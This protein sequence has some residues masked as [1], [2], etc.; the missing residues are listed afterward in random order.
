MRRVGQ[1]IGDHQLIA[2][3]QRVLVALGGCAASFCLLH[4][5]DLHRRRFVD[6]FELVPVCLDFGFDS[7]GIVRLHERLARQCFQVEVISSRACG[8]ALRGLAADE[9]PCPRCAQARRRSLREIARERGCDRIALAHHMDDGLLI[10]LQNMFFS[11]RLASLAIDLPTSDGTLHWIRPL[12]YVEAAHIAG[13]CDERKYEAVQLAC[14]GRNR[15][16][17]GPRAE[18][19]ALIACVEADFPRVRRSML[20]SLRHLRPSHL[21]DSRLLDL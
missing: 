14:P 5:L 2:G 17:H 4:M 6:D 7:P 12:L 13:F 20:A 10:L 21:L 8:Q 19:A 3:G 18:L 9:N 1:A 11:G 16:K 15:S